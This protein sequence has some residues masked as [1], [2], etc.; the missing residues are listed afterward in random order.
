MLEILS[1]VDHSRAALR[2]AVFKNYNG[3][4]MIPEAKAIKRR[5]SVQPQRLHY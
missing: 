1:K 2:F 3:N 4:A 5:S